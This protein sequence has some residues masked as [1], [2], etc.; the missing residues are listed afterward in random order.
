MCQPMGSSL[1]VSDWLVENVSSNEKLSSCFLLVARKFVD[2]E[3]GKIG[4]F[5][6]GR[7]NSVLFKLLLNDTNYLP[8]IISL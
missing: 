4:S 8:K 2:K 6:T 1:L 3:S 5:G 7:H